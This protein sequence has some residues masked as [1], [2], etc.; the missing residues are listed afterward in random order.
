MGT[1][2]E[3]W[4]FS[5]R[6]QVPILFQ[7]L[8][9]CSIYWLRSIPPVASCLAL[10]RIFFLLFFS[11]QILMMTTNSLELVN[12]LVKY[13]CFFLSVHPCYIV[14][15]FGT[16]LISHL[17]VSDSKLGTREW[18]SRENSSRNKYLKKP[19]VWSEEWIAW[20]VLSRSAYISLPN[21][22]KLSFLY[23]CKELIAFKNISL[24]PRPTQKSEL[25]C[26]KAFRPAAFIGTWFLSINACSVDSLEEKVRVYSI[27]DLLHMCKGNLTCEKVVN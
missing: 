25:G 24:F 1:S 17:V 26:L 12:M 21:L 3:V 14:M 27:L 4:F 23:H 11:K 7:F 20:N 2:S 18:W 6:C 8:A 22:Q 15:L 5:I 13:S 19:S 16:H 9:F 10:S